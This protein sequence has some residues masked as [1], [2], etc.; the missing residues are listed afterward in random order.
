MTAMPSLPEET[1]TF[2][3]L[4]RSDYGAGADPQQIGNPF[5]AGVALTGL[6]V[7]M[8]NQSC[9]NTPVVFLQPDSQAD[10][11]QGKE[12]VESPYRHQRTSFQ[13]RAQKGSLYVLQQVWAL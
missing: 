10:R 9:G 7:E 13:S 11:L 1:G 4:G 12:S 8:F 2:E 6:T 3:A 5:E